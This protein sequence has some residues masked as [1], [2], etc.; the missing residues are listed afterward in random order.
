MRLAAIL[1]TCLLL[2][3]PCVSIGRSV[4]AMAIWQSKQPQE[5]QPSNSPQHGSSAQ[6]PTDQQ[7]A[8]DQSAAPP[9]TASPA[10]RENS[11]PGSSMKSNCKP[12]QSAGA[13]TRKHHRTH[14]AIAP[15]GT[16]A[17]TGPTKTVIRNGGAADP[18]VDLSPDRKSTRL[19][20]SHTDIS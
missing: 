9:P 17:E 18:T 15:A 11:Q 3:W 13:K 7:K 14:K 4:Q 16:P 5:N 1:G 19:N 8:P 6:S 12:A 20:S 10:C 2:P